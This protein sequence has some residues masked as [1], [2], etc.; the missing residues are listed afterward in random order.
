MD[1]FERSHSCTATRAKTCGDTCPI[2]VFAATLCYFVHMDQDKERAQHLA[3]L[4]KEIVQQK[5]VGAGLKIDPKDLWGSHSREMVTEI[6]DRL[7]GAVNLSGVR[8]LILH[9]SDFMFVRILFDVNSGDEQCGEQ[10]SLSETPKNSEK[11][12]SP[13]R[14]KKPYE[15][16]TLIGGVVRVGKCVCVCVCTDATFWYS[17]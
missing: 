16:R 17:R 10:R 4:R 8:T 9:V 3:L 5:I 6:I 7:A 13:L 12:R 11:A 14:K 1:N 2:H 15:K